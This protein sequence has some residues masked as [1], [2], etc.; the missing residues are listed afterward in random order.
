[1]DLDQHH[2]AGLFAQLGL[3]NSEA[4]IQAFITAHRPLP[5]DVKL[6]DAPF[7][8]P[9]QR[10]FLKEEYIEDADWVELVD[11]LNLALRD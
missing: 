7:W 1:M 10:Q 11:Q 6:T 9:A 8:S 4:E 5:N 3:P 2:F